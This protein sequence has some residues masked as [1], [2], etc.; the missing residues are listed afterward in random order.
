MVNI[1]SKVLSTRRR[2]AI[3][4]YIIS[5]S[6]I[7]SIYYSWLSNSLLF[8]DGNFPIPFLRGGVF[9]YL[10]GNYPWFSLLYY[11]IQ[12]IDAAYLGL[13][14]NTIY[15][16]VYAFCT[17]TFYYMTITLNFSR[18]ARI[19]ASIIYIINPFT[20]YNLYNPS[21]LPFFLVI[22]LIISFIVLYSRSSYTRFLIIASVLA[23]FLVQLSAPLQ[24]LAA[25]R[26]VIPAIFLPSVLPFLLSRRSEYLRLIKSYLLAVSVFLLLNFFYIFI[27][28]YS[29]LGI[30][31]GSGTTSLNA[32][33]FNLV[34]LS[35]LYSGLKILNIF[36]DI[37]YPF[38]TTQF[39]W[40]FQVFWGIL[41]LVSIT[42]SIIWRKYI[43]P[44]IFGFIIT[45]LGIIS[46]MIFTKYG[47]DL[48]LFKKFPLLFVYE[49]PFLLESVLIFLYS[50]IL[51]FLLNLIVN[52]EIQHANH[53]KYHFSI[54]KRKNF[55]TMLTVIVTILI[56]SPLIP[57]FSNTAQL[58]NS[59][60]S[61]SKY[62]NE[63]YNEIGNYFSEHPGN[64]RTLIL[65][66]N[67]TTYNSMM[68]QVP[69]NNLFFS[70]FASVN[71]GSPDSQN[72]FQRPNQYPNFIAV[73]N[74]INNIFYNNT[75]NITEL[76]SIYN[77]EYV[78]VMNPQISQNLTM[79]I[80][81]S[82]EITLNGGGIQFVK[83][84]E[85]ATNFSV[86]CEHSDFVILRNMKYLGPL[87]IIQYSKSK[88]D[89]FSNETSLSEILLGYSQ[90]SQLPQPNAT[91]TI[92]NE[93]AISVQG[94]SY[95]FF[96]RSTGFYVLIT[97]EYVT[98]VNFNKT[99]D[100][101][102]NFNGFNIIY[103]NATANSTYDF[104]FPSF[105]NFFPL[106]VYYNVSST[107]SSFVIIGMLFL[108]PPLLKLTRK[109][110]K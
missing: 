95:S 16:L 85:T 10:S 48:L 45:A 77:V 58:S 14:T 82:G 60:A 106:L 5:L 33:A 18:F 102:E 44:E 38:L 8:F 6:I 24:G 65:P 105:N 81:S 93:S 97:S 79:Y 3:L 36:S 34:N 78:V 87:G 96:A 67:Y 103:I 49:Y 27:V 66:L 11:F 12:Q 59:Q 20:L 42:I 41:I 91:S 84:L 61:T 70:P 26:L 64:Y 39:I 100:I 25:L 28:I 72:F 1:I 90:Y 80:S 32:N 57:F 22:P 75:N 107:V 46:F 99:A 15:L 109:K 62:L 68:T 21:L 47:L 31:G 71:S 101:S 110:F 63:T 98:D 69:T 13:I 43:R 52:N 51:G 19:L 37:E 89:I 54:L 4:V 29:Y 74:V 35:Y 73:R 86:V 50:I 88:I 17:I 92:S 55:R 76:L 108:W 7:I 56:L 40:L 2:E 53:K 94:N 23:Y 83:I 104:M 9:F 30:F